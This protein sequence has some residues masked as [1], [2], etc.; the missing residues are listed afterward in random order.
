MHIGIVIWSLFETRGGIERNGCDLARNMLQ[1]GHRA[2]IFYKRPPKPRSPAYPVPDGATL[3]PLDLDFHT[4]RPEKN[5]ILIMGAAPD[6][7]VAIFSWDSLL[8]FPWLLQGTGIPLVI[9]ERSAPERLDAK[10]N[11]F[12][13]YACLNTADAIHILSQAYLEAYPMSLRPRIRVIPNPVYPAGAQA[14]S[15]QPLNGRH[16]LLAAGRFEDDIKQFSLLIKA[17]AMLAPRFPDWDLRLCGGGSSQDAYSRLAESLNLGNRFSM[18]GM[19]QDMAPEYA[20]AALFCIPSK[21]EG[22]G[23]VTVEAQSY[24]LPVVGF[25]GCSG[26]NEIIVQGENG[27]LAA[28]MTV[29]SLAQSLMQLMGD[30]N[31][32]ERMGRRG[33]AMLQRYAP[34]TV[35][36]AWEAMLFDAAHCHPTHIDALLAEK[37]SPDNMASKEILARSHPFDRSAYL[38]LAGQ[39]GGQIFSESEFRSFCKKQKKYGLT[40]MRK[41]LRKCGFPFV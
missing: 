11:A 1:R 34:K 24:G 37:E 26:T 21:S 13:R 7:L 38:R 2:S 31:L 4:R 23:M 25:A 35:Y 10:W 15:T 22:F 41:V 18:P 28:E 9:S 20:R 6:V 30:T 36:D 17:F 3:Y 16:I 39:R 33:K 14:D 32:R 27:L 5:R 19:M 12:E 29:E 8:W 40:G